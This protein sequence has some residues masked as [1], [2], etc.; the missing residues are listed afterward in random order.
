[1]KTTTT[2]AISKHVLGCAHED[3][4]EHTL[5]FAAHLEH[6]FEEAQTIPTPPQRQGFRALKGPECPANMS[7][8]HK[9]EAT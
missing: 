1:M 9:K 8:K 3:A 2:I 4:R 6:S 7:R 5:P